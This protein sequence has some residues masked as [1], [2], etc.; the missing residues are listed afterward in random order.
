MRRKRGEKTLVHYD[1]LLRK[2]IPAKIKKPYN[3]KIP[4]TDEGSKS[5]TIKVTKLT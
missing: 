1:Y 3:P 2:A 4:K 5:K